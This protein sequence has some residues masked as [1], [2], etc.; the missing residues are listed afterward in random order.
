MRF[1]LCSLSLLFGFSLTAQH[2]T[3]LSDIDVIGGFGGPILETSQINGQIGV[4]VGGGGAL[5]LNGFFLGG[6]GMGTD[7]ATYSITS[8]ENEGDYEIDFGHGGLWLGYSH[9]PFKLA[10][11]FLSTKL[12]WGST[13]LKEDGDAMFKDRIFVLTPEL[14]VEFNVTK[15][16]R[17]AVTG[18]YRWV[19]GIQD[20]PGLDNN[21]FSS[22][23][24]TI[25]FSF[26]GFAE[27]N[28]WDDDEDW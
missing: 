3:L 18:G 6:Y 28:D 20:L 22:P 17:I 9:N 23:T 26:G 5:L 25:T 10:H 14:G 2:E 27:D 8:G 19:N 12:G 15:W 1:L 16:F 13:E 21:D 11:L 4:D 7:Y 24:G